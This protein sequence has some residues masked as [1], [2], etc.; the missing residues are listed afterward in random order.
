[1]KFVFLMCN[2][3]LYKLYRYDLNVHLR[4]LKINFAKRDVIFCYTVVRY[5]IRCKSDS[6]SLY[7]VKRIHLKASLSRVQIYVN[8]SARRILNLAKFGN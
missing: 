4:M 5:G 1:M 3:T 2:Q 6:Q 7:D 8:A